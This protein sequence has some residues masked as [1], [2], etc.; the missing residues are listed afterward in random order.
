MD[1]LI[2]NFRIVYDD[3][4]TK[5]PEYKDVVGKSILIVRAFKV[6]QDVDNVQDV[7][8]DGAYVRTQ[9]DTALRDFEANRNNNVSNHLLYNGKYKRE[10]V[11]DSFQMVL[12]KR[13][14]EGL[15]NDY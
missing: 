6:Y 1:H 13:N 4:S 14:I 5:Y 10:C 11:N 7:L 9:Y 3:F 12:N 2:E 8:N 15:S